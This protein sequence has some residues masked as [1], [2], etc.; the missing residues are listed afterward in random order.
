MRHGRILL[1]RDVR[2]GRSVQ[3]NAAA[4]AGQ[5]TP[6]QLRSSINAC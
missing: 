1:V 6:G 2:V 3:A 5:R 4:A